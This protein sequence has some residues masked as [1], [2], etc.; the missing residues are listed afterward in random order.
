MNYKGDFDGMQNA[1]KRVNYVW[2]VEFQRV[3]PLK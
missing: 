2:N 3:L 1:I